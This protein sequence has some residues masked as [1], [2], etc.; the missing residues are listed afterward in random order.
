MR[1]LIWSLFLFA[2]TGVVATIS[3]LLE[4][5]HLVNRQSNASSLNA[6][7]EEILEDIEEAATSSDPCGVCQVR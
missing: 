2:A 1:S 5:Q 7:L 6:T 4:D 3:N